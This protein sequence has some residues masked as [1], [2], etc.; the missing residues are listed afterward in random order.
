VASV[1]IDGDATDQ[2][3]LTRY[4]EIKPG[5]P[6]DPELVRHVVELFY[7]TGEYADVV[8][9]TVPAA[10]GVEVVFPPVKAPLLAEVRVEGDRL[11]KP[12]AL[13][14][15]GA[16]APTRARSGRPASSRRRGTSPWVWPSGDTSRPA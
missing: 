5:Q 9:E 3:R 15:R 7:A 11:V 4:V 1:R 13:R 12:E 8:V 10:G 6:L 2:A 16:P 14:P